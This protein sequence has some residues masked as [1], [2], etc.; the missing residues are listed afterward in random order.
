MFYI[1]IY[2]F[3]S[4]SLVITTDHARKIVLSGW[5]RGEQEIQGIPWNSLSRFPTDWRILEARCLGPCAALA[6]LV[7][8]RADVLAFG[9]C[10]SLTN[11][12]VTQLD[13]LCFAR[14]SPSLYS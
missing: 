6:V 9:R 11:Q 5:A 2:I 7:S 14:P 12:H 10:P 8:F 1:Y 3:T 4:S 13:V